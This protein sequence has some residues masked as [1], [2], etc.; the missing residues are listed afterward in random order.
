MREFKKLTMYSEEEVVYRCSNSSSF[1]EEPLVPQG[2]SS[3]EVFAIKNNES[4]PT[5]KEAFIGFKI[6]NGNFH[7]IGVPFTEPRKAFKNAPLHNRDL[8]VQE[9]DDLTLDQM[10]KLVGFLNDIKKKND[11]RI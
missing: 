3:F 7:F 2:A 9:I 5:G 11:I 4:S 1:I 6:P 8:I 10:F